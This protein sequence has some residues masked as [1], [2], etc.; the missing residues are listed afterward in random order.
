[1][2][3]VFMKG[4]LVVMFRNIESGLLSLFVSFTCFLIG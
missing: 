4:E 1:M 3:N 2:S